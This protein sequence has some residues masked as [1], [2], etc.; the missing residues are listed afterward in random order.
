MIIPRCETECERERAGEREK[1]RENQK[2][3]KLF[4]QKLFHCLV[5]SLALLHA[6]SK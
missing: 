6:Q 2:I 1:E 4:Q 3:I 5:R